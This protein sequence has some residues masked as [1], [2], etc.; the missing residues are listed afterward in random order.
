MWNARTTRWVI[1]FGVEAS[2]A[3]MKV[4]TPSP[5]PRKLVARTVLARLRPG[6][7]GTAGGLE[8]SVVERA[9]N[10]LTLE[11][12]GL[13]RVQAA[14]YIGVSPSLFDEMVTDGRMPPPKIINSRRVWDRREL[15]EAFDAIPPKETRDPWDCVLS[16]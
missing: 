5:Y 6:H 2:S 9:S 4:G 10:V 15:D 7:S 13:N 8:G 12:R 16:A 11:P 1:N 3:A 14:G